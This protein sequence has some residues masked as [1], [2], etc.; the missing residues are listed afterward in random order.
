[1]QKLVFYRK[2]N[3]ILMGYPFRIKNAIFIYENSIDI[4]EHHSCSM[5]I[6]ILQHV[7]IENTYLLLFKTLIETLNF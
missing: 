2:Q 5:Y 3:K 7:Y 1:M 6:D 4:I